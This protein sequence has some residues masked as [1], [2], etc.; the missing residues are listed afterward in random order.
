MSYRGLA[1]LDVS[2]EHLD[3][4]LEARLVYLTVL[5]ETG[6]VRQPLLQFE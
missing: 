2:T 5:Q 6:A 1:W 3:L 4:G